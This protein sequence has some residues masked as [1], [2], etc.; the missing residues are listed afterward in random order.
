MGT[1][2]RTSMFITDRAA[3]V[4]E[5]ERTAEFVAS[6]GGSVNTYAGPEVLRVKGMSL[7]R[8]R[9][10]PVVLDCHNRA[11]ADDVIGI[12]AVRKSGGQLIARVQF[13][14]DEKSQRIFDK[15][16][17]GILRAVSIGFTVDPSAIRE[18]EDGEVDGDGDDKVRGPA[19]VINRSELH[20]I[21]VVPVPADEDALRRDFYKRCLMADPK[22]PEAPPAET[23]ADPEALHVEF[24]APPSETPGGIVAEILAA[25]PPAP[26]PAPLVDYAAECA[27]I[28]GEAA[29]I[30]AQ[31]V[32][33]KAVHESIWDI[34]PA[35][36]DE[37]LRTLL[38]SDPDI[39]LESARRELL[40]ERTKN[41]KPIGT[42]EPAPI[43]ST[44]APK[45]L[46]AGD[47]F[48]SLTGR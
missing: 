41:F 27:R 4:D 33:R 36:L 40:K 23:P 28:E 9:K 24:D 10:N 32:R 39:T 37:H 47:L 11:S 29:M 44:P 25:A 6:S 48:Q 17:E 18:L 42:P 16:R 3:Q 12:A 46:D 21:S 2:F 34:C 13:A 1:I 45:S 8:Y 7:T 19:I 30:R 31:S 20:E 5:E 43:Q 38:V 15:V 14:S 35:D 26:P 22:E